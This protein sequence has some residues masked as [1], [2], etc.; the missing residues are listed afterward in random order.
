MRQILFALWAFA[1]A[2]CA[3][4][5]KGTILAC[6]PCPSS[7]VCVQDPRNACEPSPDGER[8]AA[9]CISNLVPC[10]GIAA[11]QC[12]P[13]MACVDDPRDDCDPRAGGADCSRNCAP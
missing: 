1:V 12:P 5:P 8:C 6:P 9:L 13:G 3:N 4:A 7:A 11:R 10:G 2:A